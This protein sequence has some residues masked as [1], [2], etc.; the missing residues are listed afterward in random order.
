MTKS[1]KVQ[2]F[3]ELKNIFLVLLGCF[4]LA[5]SDALF[6]IPNNIVNGGV[7]SIG[8]LVNYYFQDSVGFDLSDIVV[9]VIQLLLWILGLFFLGKK[10][11]IH[12]LLGT[13]AFPA[14]YSL[15]LRTHVYEYCGL[16]AF[17][18]A[19]QD[20]IGAMILAGVFGGGIAGVGVAFTYLGDGSTGGTDI[21]CFIIEKYARITQD[22]SGMAMDGI[23]ILAALICMKDW[24]LAMCGV[25]SSITAALVIYLVYVKG[26][27]SVLCNIVTSKPDKIND[28]IQHHLNHGTT[29][30][31]GNSGRSGEKRMI[32]RAVMYKEEADDLKNFIALVDPDS[33]VT[34]A[35]LDDTVGQGFTPL[36]A[37]PRNRRKLLLKYGVKIKESKKE[38]KSKN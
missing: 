21:L 30:L 32:V 20:S 16:K 6:I 8:V 25:L 34:F 23:L 3:L 10:F 28:F 27:D 26:N 14:F 9:A 2:F 15:L 29:I 7:D 33:F 24:G 12:T 22:L 38:E 37:S 1:K 18:D 5:L 17:F 36:K 4:L 31:E 19:H 13:L 35:S 11:S